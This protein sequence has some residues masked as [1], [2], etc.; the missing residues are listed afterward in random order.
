[1]ANKNR[2]FLASSSVTRQR[3]LFQAGVKF[4]TAYPNVDEIEIKSSFIAEN[5]SGASIAEALAE[6]KARPISLKNPNAYVIGSDQILEVESKILSKPLD[7]VAARDQ[8]LHLRGKNHQLYS[9]VC[10]LCNGIRLWHVLDTASMWMREFSERFLRD[11]LEALGDTALNFPGAYCIDDRG[12]QLFS[13]IEGD[14]FTVLGLPLL[15]LLSY[16]RE[17]EVIKL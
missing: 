2:V 17:Q 4:E 10:V 12:I 16:L 7:M 14:Y 15:P 6:N 1:M 11:Y 13:K 3:I 9:F 8:L 5:F